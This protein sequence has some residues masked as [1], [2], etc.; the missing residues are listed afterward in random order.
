MTLRLK[1]MIKLALAGGCLGGAIALLILKII[2]LIKFWGFEFK[3]HKNS[4]VPPS[5]IVLSFTHL[6]PCP[7]RLF[8]QPSR[9]HRS[10]LIISVDPTLEF[11]G[12]P[13]HSQ[14]LT[15]SWA[16]TDPEMWLDKIGY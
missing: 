1:N 16:K 7:P 6:S 15:Q 3:I 2:G 13:A 9:S 4:N 5:C 11:F 12:L 8:Q 10:Y 14:E